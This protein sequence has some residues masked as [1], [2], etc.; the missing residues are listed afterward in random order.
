[1]FQDGGLWDSLELPTL[2]GALIGDQFSLHRT[3]TSFWLE[4]EVEVK[5]ASP[6]MVL[7]IVFCTGHHSGVQ[8]VSVVLLAH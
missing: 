2:T 6:K 1:M 8:D 3:T 5:H 7:C 4:F